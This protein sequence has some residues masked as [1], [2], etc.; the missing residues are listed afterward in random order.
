MFCASGM[1]FGGAYSLWLLNRI[2]FGNIKNFSIS[3]YQ[4]LTRL[5][6]YYLFPFGFLTVLL[7]IYPELLICYIYMI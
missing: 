6:F 3:E 5:E 4:D 1:V 2:L 7:G